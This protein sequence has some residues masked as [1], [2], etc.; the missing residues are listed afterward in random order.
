MPSILGSLEL[1]E[2]VLQPFGSPEGRNNVCP[3]CH[4]TSN[5]AAGLAESQ[6]ASGDRQLSAG[7]L[8]TSLTLVDSLKNNDA[9][10]WQRLV[11]LYAPRFATGVAGGRCSR[12][13]SG[14]CSRTSSS[15]SSAAWRSSTRTG[16]PILPCLAEDDH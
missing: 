14:T 10:G 3:V 2:P 1:Q 4:P 7:G 16:Q 15:T 13:T 5:E 11:Q 6:G 12:K 9:S 8:V